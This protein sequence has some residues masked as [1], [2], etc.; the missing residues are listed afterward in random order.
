MS[1]LDIKTP[2]QAQAVVDQL[3]RSVERR[4]AASPP[5]LC[6]IDMALNFLNL[7]HAQTC[8]KC[9][10]CRIGLGQLSNM[11][12]AVLDGEAEMRAIHRIEVTAQAIVDTADCAIGINAAQLVLMG[13]KGFRDDYEEHILRHRCLGGLKNPVPCVA[14]CPAG[15]DIPGYIALINAGRYDD[16]VRLV[17]KD[18]PFPT[19]CAYICEH[20]C[21]ARCRRNMVDDPVNIRGLKRYAVDHAGDVPQPSCAPSTGKTVA[22]VGG[23]PGGLSAAYYLSLMGHKVTV[24]EKQK[25]LGGMLRYGIPSYRF[26]REKLDA[27]IAS[28]LSLGIE[29]KTEVDVGTDP[30]LDDLRRQYDCLYLSI[31]AHTDKKTGI[32]GEDSHGVVSAVELLRHIGD[33]EM[34]DFTG[35]NVVV[36]GGGNVAMDVTRSAIRLGSKKV[37]CV[38]RR[39]QADMTAQQEEVEG[40]IAEGAEILTLQAPLRIEANEAGNVAALWTQPQVIGE[41]DAMGRPRPTT[42]DVEPKRIPA[43]LIIV[44]I[45]QGIE[46]HGFEQIGVKIQR[47]GT[48][49]ADA[50]TQLPDVEG[51]FAG[52]DCVTGPATVIRAIAAGKAAAANIDV[53]LG[54][55][56]EIEADISIPTPDLSDLRPRGRINTT[57]RDASERKHDFQCIECGFTGEEAEKESSRCL[58]CDHF[59]YGIFKGGRVDKW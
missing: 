24:Y 21:E 18:N 3:Y 47:G 33:G 52:G 10:P 8:G 23:G 57:V 20:P 32:P 55:N 49:L 13:L 9:A 15:V 16:A 44:A 51:V 54:F 4:I 34:P 38:Y 27:E 48:L 39:R 45:G 41:V 14:L 30:S 12:Q 53:Y 7:C 17:R 40:A 25:M 59:G 35:M 2:S 31:G 29:V 5:G 36:I 11:L 6:P 56:H 46:T 26:P 28:I 42:A 58:R 37:S 22:V 19:A 43:D 50:S 1:R